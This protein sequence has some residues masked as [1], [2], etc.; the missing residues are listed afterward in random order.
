MVI[1][2]SAAGGTADVVTHPLRMCVSPRLTGKRCFPL[3][4]YPIGFRTSAFFPQHAVTGKASK[5]QLVVT[6]RQLVQ[7]PINSGSLKEENT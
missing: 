7:T 2:N 3:L 5:L 1:H 6:H 4:W